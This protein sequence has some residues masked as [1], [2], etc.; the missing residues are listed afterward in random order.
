MQYLSEEWLQ[1]ASTAVA[2]LDAESVCLRVGY[3]VTDAPD[4]VVSYT[5]VLGDGTARFEVGTADV[6]ASLTLS[7]ELAVAI[8]TGTASA[9]RAFLDGEIRLGGSVTALLGS[10][11]PLQAV[12][13]RLVQLRVGTTF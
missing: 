12:D 10:A 5:L 9:Q 11:P 4:H 2:E 7:Y 13:D 8:A 1:A 3:R 6:D